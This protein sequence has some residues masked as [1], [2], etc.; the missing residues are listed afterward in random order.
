MM[1]GGQT[2][3][4]R[5]SAMTLAC[6]R[7]WGLTALI[8]SALSQPVAAQ[9]SGAQAQKSEPAQKSETT[10]QPVTDPLGRSTPRGT[11]MGFL[12]AVE[13]NDASAV[14]YLE[15]T[16]GESP[17][18]LASARD[19]SNLINRYLKEP[20]A[21]VSDSPDGTLNEGLPT[22]RERVGPLILGDRTEDIT[23]VRVTD[24]QAATCMTTLPRYPP[25]LG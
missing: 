6:L 20:L 24:P 3:N 9:I 12:R 19:L 25:S 21:K 22:N 14:R 23:L 18:A 5:E 11:L 15:V 17:N 4:V 7:R 2:L 8:L 13:K 16:A 10:A 1:Q